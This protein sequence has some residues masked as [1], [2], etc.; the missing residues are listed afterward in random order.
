M[1]K[2]SQWN[3]FRPVF[4][5]KNSLKASKIDNRLYLLQEMKAKYLLKPNDQKETTKIFINETYS[6]PQLGIYPTNKII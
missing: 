5:N 1:F 2:S 6:K 4:Y 3:N